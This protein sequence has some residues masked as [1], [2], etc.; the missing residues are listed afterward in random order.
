MALGLVGGGLKILGGAAK[1][2][3]GGMK[4]A[5]K[6]FKR[7]DDKK[8]EL[9]QKET[10]EE[11]SESTVDKTQNPRISFDSPDVSQSISKAGGGGESESL[12]GT[13]FRIK[14]SVVDIDTLLKGSLALD[15]MRATKKRRI[16]KQSRRKKQETKFEK[17]KSVGKGLGRFV[18]KKAK[19][20]IGRVINF[21]VTMFWGF[22]ALKFFDQL[23]K[24]LGLVTILNNVMNW[25][26]KWGG[27]ILNAFVTLVHWGDKMFQ[28]LRKGVGKLFGKKGQ[29][30]FDKLS[31]TLK[32]VLNLAA[33][34]ALTTA[35]VLMKSTSLAYWRGFR[36]GSMGGKG[37]VAGN[38][39]KHGLRRA[40]KR[41][42]IK[43][44][45]KGKAKAVLGF[46]KAALAKTTAFAAGIGTFA[47]PAVA[48]AKVIAVMGLFTA[49]G[50][51]GGQLTTKG[52]Q[53]NKGLEKNAEENKKLKWWNPKR[54]G[55]WMLWKLGEVANRVFGAFF[56]L[57]DILGTPIRYLIELVRY[58]FL[59]QQ[60]KDKQRKNMAKFDGRI[61]EQF[62]R[63]F[64]AFDFLGKVSDE[65][66]GW[67]N[68]YGQEGRAGA[69]QKD[70]NRKLNFDPTGDDKSASISKS[71]SYEEDGPVTIVIN[72]SGSQK[73][74]SSPSGMSGDTAELLAGLSGGNTSRGDSSA[75]EILH[76][77]A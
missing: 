39:L 22:L 61:R 53:W 71:T 59:D 54:W 17:V 28:G 67:G 1:K 2:A 32:W 46:G 36:D 12:E 49:V 23:P 6:I 3:G 7:K 65:T 74:S 21:F 35:A 38:I 66:G 50:E 51:G 44:L 33:I 77:G 18:P 75:F 57:L 8:K 64:N 48:A 11:T 73:E 45:G 25:L 27:R 15:K 37:R 62:R 70:L 40:P 14:K 69:G 16:A 34:A 41:L 19:S 29:A 13:A 68:I 26:V 20:V 60:G 63:L 10:G 24:L 76:K 43:L 30:I 5:R 56:G 72:D 31:G 42:L 9:P 47:A 4:M 52:R 55:S 58:P